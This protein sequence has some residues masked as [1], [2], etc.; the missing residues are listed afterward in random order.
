MFIKALPLLNLFP[1]I[2]SVYGSETKVFTN[3]AKSEGL[4][5]KSA[6]WVTTRSPVLCNTPCFTV[7]DLPKF[8]LLCKSLNSESLLLAFL[9]KEVTNS[10]VLSVEESLTIMISFVIPFGSSTALTFSR[11]SVIVPS[12]L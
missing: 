8:I 10:T 3:L 1:Y 5:S 11:S 7:W 9:I 6:S 2:K 4:Y 12:S